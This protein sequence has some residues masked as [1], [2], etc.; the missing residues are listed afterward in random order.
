[1]PQAKEMTTYKPAK[2]RA[3][4]ARLGFTWRGGQL[5]DPRGHK[6]SI[7]LAVIGGWTDWVLVCQILQKNFQAIGIDASIKIMDEAGWTD[8]ADKGLLS[9]HLH[10]TNGGL[11][12]YY[13]F[14]GYMSRQSYVPTGQDASANGQTNWERWWSPEAT[15]LLAQFR[16]TTDA[17]TQRAIV[18]R[19]QKNQLDAFPYI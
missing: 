14:Y 16:H 3:L 4:L 19:L 1:M 2:A 11:T 7:Q 12:P 17:S 15:Q 9:A 8:K 13:Y 5:Y 6:V 18:D 10:W